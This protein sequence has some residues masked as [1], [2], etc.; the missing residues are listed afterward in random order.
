MEAETIS[1]SLPPDHLEVEAITIPNV[2]YVMHSSK[3]TD[4]LQPFLHQVHFAFVVAA[5]AAGQDSTFGQDIQ[6][7]S[8]QGPHHHNILPVALHTAAHIHL[9]AGNAVVDHNTYVV[10]FVASRQQ[11]SVFVPPQLVVLHVSQLPSLP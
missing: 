10:V 7:H 11:E 1:D 6:V 4:Y 9:V 3:G 8:P 2:N 5:A